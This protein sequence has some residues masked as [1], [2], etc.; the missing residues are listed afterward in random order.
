MVLANIRF[1]PYIPLLLACGITALSPP[2]MASLQGQR[3]QDWGGNCEAGAYNRNIC[4]LEQVLSH[5]DQPLMITVIGYA[6]GKPMPTIFFELPKDIA[7]QNGIT[8]QV[9]NQAP[10]RFQGQC[11]ETR[12]TAGFALDQK[13]LAQFRKG[14]RATVSYQGQADS[15][16]VQLP[17]SLMGISAGLNALQRSAS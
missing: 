17:L 2:A 5:N 3:F 7:I 11:N 1:L 15:R 8:L 4:Y 6:P 9:D 13:I 14:R 12:C 16:Q 10:I